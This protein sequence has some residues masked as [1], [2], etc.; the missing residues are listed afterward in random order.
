MEEEIV[1]LYKQGM[2]IR[3]IV[4]KLHCSHYDV[5]QCFVKNGLDGKVESK[6]EIVGKLRKEGYTYDAISEKTGIPKGTLV[7][8]TR[9]GVRLNDELRMKIVDAIEADK[10]NRDI[11]SELN[12]DIMDVA[13]VR[14]WLDGYRE[15]VKQYND[16]VPQRTICKNFNNNTAMLKLYRQLAMSR[17][18]IAPRYNRGDESIVTDT[19][20]IAKASI[21]CTENFCKKSEKS[22]RVM[23][24]FDD[25]DALEGRIRFLRK[26]L[27]V[28][29][30]RL[31]AAKAFKVYQ[32]ALK[33]LS[34]VSVEA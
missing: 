1:N 28:A 32:D 5:W 27:D 11:A 21:D 34:Q 8:Y 25:L 13:V 16:G 14:S 31:E 6:R 9:H 33:E 30:K 22:L 19:V 20:N 12:V 2:S 26:E 24:D 15:Y 18:D 29:E 23:S 4:A 10:D 3:D 17:G 7:R